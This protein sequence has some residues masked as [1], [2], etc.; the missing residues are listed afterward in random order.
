MKQRIKIGARHDVE[1]LVDGAF[2]ATFI[3]KDGSLRTMACELGVSVNLVGGK[4]NTGDKPNLLTVW[5]VSDNAY[6]IINTDTLQTIK[7]RGDEYEVV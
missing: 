7:Y 2:E 5:S 3:K 4:N 6:R 1:N